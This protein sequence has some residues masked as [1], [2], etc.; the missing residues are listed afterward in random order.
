MAVNAT[1]Y[2]K[3]I[4]DVYKYLYKLALLCQTCLCKH[5]CSFEVPYSLPGPVEN[6]LK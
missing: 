2:N 5:I 4:I 1:I 6:T 3:I